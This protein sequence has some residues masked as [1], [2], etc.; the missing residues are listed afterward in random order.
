M[1]TTT[2]TWD[3]VKIDHSS[4]SD[5]GRRY[6]RCVWVGR[7]SVDD[8]PDDEEEKAHECRTEHQRV[9]PAELLDTDQ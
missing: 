9:P 2:H 5:T 3:D 1:G 7:V 6:G 4:G 8:R